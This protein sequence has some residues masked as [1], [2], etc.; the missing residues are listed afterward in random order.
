MR[1]SALTKVK[2]RRNI[3]YKN[4]NQNERVK[5]K[6]KQNN[7]KRQTHEES[8]IEDGIISC[9]LLIQ[10]EKKFN[11][12]KKFFNLEFFFRKIF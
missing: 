10:L 7:L 12:E 2:T 5:S 6:R 1:H 4:I 3:L 8:Y 11:C 9:C